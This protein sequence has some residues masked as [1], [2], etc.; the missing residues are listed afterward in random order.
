MQ[1]AETREKTTEKIKALRAGLGLS[2]AKLHGLPRP[3]LRPPG[4]RESPQPRPP[5]IGEFGAGGESGE[6][7]AGKNGENF[8]G[9]VRA[10]GVRHERRVG[11]G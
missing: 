1:D 4:D 7:S 5:P 11:G 9:G 2:Q 3:V 10:E 6:K 8:M